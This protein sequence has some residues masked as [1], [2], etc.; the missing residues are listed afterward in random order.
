LRG[1]FVLAHLRT[2]AAVVLSVLV[3]AACGGGGSGAGAGQD[4]PVVVGSANFPE[5]LILGN[6][7]ALVLEDAGFEV[8]RRLNLGSREVIFPAI[9]EG[10]VDV[11]PE[12]L[13]ALSAF[14]SEGEEES[15]TDPQ[16]LRDVLAEELPDDLVLLESSDAQDQ[17]A[18]AVTAETA[19]ELDLQSVSD[20]APVAGDLTLGGPAETETRYVGVPGLKEVYGIEFGEFRA[21]DAGG[22][23]TTEA[24]NSGDIDVGRVF[25]TQ[26]VIDEFGWVV[27]EDDMGLVPAENITPLAREEIVTEDLRAALNELSETLTTEELTELNKQVEVDKADPEDV[28]RDWLV[29]Q[30]LIEG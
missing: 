22:P 7:Y 17:D 21:L 4:G 8:E 14:V 15:I 18:L 3:L 23:L 29:E 28:A 5:Q 20:L 12:Y 1:L 2:L 10:E 26:G 30:G 11:L 13:G 16:E 6:M 19:E 25:T 27:L 24:L 9:A